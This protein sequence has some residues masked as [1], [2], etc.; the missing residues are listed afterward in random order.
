M[1]SEKIQVCFLIF[2]L[3]FLENTPQ[4]V[5][6]G[7][8]RPLAPPASARPVKIGLKGELHIETLYDSALWVARK[9][10]HMSAFLGQ[11]SPLDAVYMFQLAKF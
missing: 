1:L 4:V 6:A 3:Y 7:A 10:Q 2:L 5:E 9:L 8:S 11:V